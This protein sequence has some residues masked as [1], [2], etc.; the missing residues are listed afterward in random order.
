MKRNSLFFVLIV[1][2][3]VALLTI[4]GSNYATLQYGERLLLKT[5]PIDPRDLFHGDYVIL[6][7]DISS[8]SLS[9]WEGEDKFESREKV[10][11]VLQKKDKY[12]DAI[13]IYPDK[14][15]VDDGKVVLKGKAQYE[16]AGTV[17][18]DYGIERYYVEEGTGKSIEKQRELTDV[19]VRVAPWGQVA[20]EAL[21]INK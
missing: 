6:N 12:Y 17:F 18:I 3:I 19:V 2:Q 14:P 21:V 9:L 15:D 13:G 10:Y 20:I 11:V 5:E 8:L 7:Y 16:H 1:F 4:A